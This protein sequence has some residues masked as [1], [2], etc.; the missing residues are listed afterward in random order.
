MKVCYLW[1]DRFRNFENQGFNFASDVKFHYDGRSGRLT[2]TNLD[3]LPKDFFVPSDPEY[4]HSLNEGRFV[5]VTGLIGRNGG[6]KSNVL[7]ALLKSIKGAKSTMPTDFLLVLEDEGVYKYYV[8]FD[9]NPNL[10]LEDNSEAQIFDYEGSIKGLKAVFF[11]NVYDGRENQFSSSISDIS[12]NKRAR[13]LSYYRIGEN[14]D[15]EKQI[16]FIESKHFD[17]LNIDTPQKA[18]F[19]SR[20][21]NRW[22]SH[23]VHQMFS[24][25]YDKFRNH[26]SDFRKRLY[27]MIPRN[28][29]FAL[30]KYSFILSVFD[31]LQESLSDRKLD[32]GRELVERL[33]LEIRGKRTDETL[34]NTLHWLEDVFI[35]NSLAIEE[36]ISRSRSRRNSERDNI[37]I[38]R[39]QF[40]FLI[41][42][43]FNFD[44]IK[45]DVEVE[46][47]RSSRNEWFYVSYR[48]KL[49]ISFIHEFSKL[50]RFD[51][52]FATDWI[53]LS[54]GHK[55]YLNMF[56]SIFNELRL[57]RSENLLLCIDEGDLY[58]HP[59]WQTEFFNKLLEILPQIFSKNIQ[60]I[61]TSHSPFILSDLPNQCVT[62]VEPKADS[63]KRIIDASQLK[64]KTLAGNIYELYREPFF[65]DQK[66]TSDFAASKINQILRLIEKKDITQRDKRLAE[67]LIDLIGDKV[68]NQY[69]TN[70]LENA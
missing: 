23:R 53:G 64:I 17:H 6:G 15:F 14:S 7:D 3:P 11:S 2:K 68:V 54:S 1:V 45:V 29:F 36:H 37:N 27:D 8:S 31:L 49:S 24:D 38:M 32:F 42:M 51:P 58:L 43:Q 33:S 66:R 13:R 25:S 21:L 65:L 18:Q 62:I 52:F 26:Q 44:D 10:R 34:D 5:D 60:L 67:R 63:D 28:R 9:S 16:R 70:R 19:R 30:I 59:K 47:S 20:A 46:G 40:D 55:A 12:T 50:F 41:N 61:I 56:A 4:N 22:N 48:D 57:S 69:L 39:G 35:S